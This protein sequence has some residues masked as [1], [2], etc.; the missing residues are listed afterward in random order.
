MTV[1]AGEVEDIANLL[2]EI[3][4]LSVEQY[5]S[6]AYEAERI[7]AGFRWEEIAGELEMEVYRQIEGKSSMI[8]T[9]DL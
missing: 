2:V 1:E 9:S 6:L 3:L 5:S 8:S 7:S 4:E